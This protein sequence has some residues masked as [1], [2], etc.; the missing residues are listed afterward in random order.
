MA[1]T[2]DPAARESAAAAEAWALSELRAAEPETAG[3]LD[4]EM[5]AAESE[6]GPAGETV[7]RGPAEAAT[8]QAF[9]GAGGGLDAELQELELE[10]G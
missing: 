5:A 2:M 9:L 8:T 3:A 4:A 10:A 7:W 1:G 6:R